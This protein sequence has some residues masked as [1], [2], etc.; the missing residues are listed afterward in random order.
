[1]HLCSDVIELDRPWW[2][3]TDT[4]T[5][6]P[7]TIPGTFTWPFWLPAPAMACVTLKRPVEVL[8]SPHLVDHQPL[9]KRKRCGPPLFPT[10]PSPPRGIK[11]AKRKLEVD[12]HYSSPSINSSAAVSPFL[13]A[14]PPLETGESMQI[15]TCVVFKY[16]FEIQTKTKL[17]YTRCL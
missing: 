2:F 14:T 13:R 8:G 4:P 7:H 3:E 1:M 9:A 12:D 5:F 15:R 11:R 17:L 16:E 6:P 10:T